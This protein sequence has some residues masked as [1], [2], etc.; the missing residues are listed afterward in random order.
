MEKKGKDSSKKKWT[1]KEIE[2]EIKRLDEAITEAKETKGDVDVRDAMFDKAVFL[3]DVARYEEDAE[4]MFRETIEKS[5]GPSKKMEILFHILQMTIHNIDIPKIKKDIETCKGLVDEG[6]D[7]EKKNKLK[8]YEGV[9]C[10][11]IRDFKR[12]AELFLDSVATF[13]CSELLDYKE[14]V[15]YTVVTAMVSLDRGTIRKN[16]VNSPDILAVI[17]DVDHLKKFSDSFYNCN[18]KSFFEAFVE[19]SDRIKENKFL[20]K[21]SN[22]FVKEMRL[23]A[24]KQF[25]ASYKSVTIQNMAENFGVGAD[26]LDKELSH[27]ISIGKIK[28]KIDKVAGVI[29]SNTPD[30]KIEQYNQM[31]KKG[32]FLLDRIQKLGRA[33]DI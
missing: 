28:C 5:G 1:V 30:K 29:E 19:I 11:I 4:T 9:Y 12:A 33:L 7:W 3:K 22:Y 16:V 14:F 15:F 21:H 24:Y 6:A 17:R 20:G 23:V 18:Y 10:M 31:L 8:V 26:F 27:F 2:K 25:L 32:D 13:T